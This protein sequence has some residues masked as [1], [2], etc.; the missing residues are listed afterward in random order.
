MAREITLRVP[1]PVLKAAVR[2]VQ[3]RKH[4]HIRKATRARGAGSRRAEQARIDK[5]DV[6]TTRATAALEAQD[7]G[8]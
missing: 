5:L 1:Q 6:F 7:G 2:A 3:A 4:H 8:A